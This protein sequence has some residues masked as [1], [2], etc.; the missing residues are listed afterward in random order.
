[1]W[2]QGFLAAL[3]PMSLLWLLVGTIWGLVVGVL[4]ALG[5]NF[6]V[7][8]MLP[9]T[10]GMDPG[11]AL[12]FLTA[13]HAST[14]Y[15]DSLSSILL[16][17]PGGPG[18][19]A[20]CW[21]G[22]PMARQGKAGRALGIA[23][24]SSFIGGS[25]AWLSLALLAR[26]VG[27]L[28]LSIGAPEYFALGV[29]ALSLVS[30][31]ARGETIKGLI[32]VCLGLLLASIGQD[33]V[34]GVSYRFA[35]GLPWLEAGI[36]IVVSTLGIFAMAQIMNLMEETSIGTA[37]MEVKDSIFGGFLETL[38]RPLTL[39]RAGLVGWFIG[40]LPALG[41]SLAGISSYLVEKHYSRE[42][43]HFGA[44]APAGLVAAE[45]GKGACVVGD[46]IPTFTLGVPGSVTGAILMAALVIHG[47]DPGPRFLL[48]GVLP[49]MVFASLFLSQAAYLLIGPGVCRA[50]AKIIFLPNAI[51][52]PVITVLAFVGAF[53]ERNF[54]FDILVMLAF[55][56]LAYGLNRIGYP[57]VCLVLGLI[58][59]DMVESNL[60]RSLGIGFGSYAIF[61][62]RPIAVVLLSVTLLF[63]AYP[64]LLRFF[65]IKGLE[66]VGE[67]SGEGE[68]AA[69]GAVANRAEAAALIVVGLV[70]AAFILIGRKYP[71]EV[72]LFPT[73]VAYVGLPITLFRLLGLG[74]SM[75]RHRGKAPGREK[76][77]ESQYRPVTPW[78][79]SFALFLVYALLVYLAGFVL[80]TVVF[81]IVTGFTAGYRKLPVLVAVGIGAGVFTLVFARLLN[82]ILPLGAIFEAILDR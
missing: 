66:G 30:V 36:P 65:G 67:R 16:N 31:A 48:S 58:L 73:L 38:R 59:G 50:L 33:P 22:H 63:L 27:E 51:L 19:V 43:D 6:S 54:T 74:W 18:T 21:D 76:P 47:I 23:T 2:F 49:Y 41:V 40:I 14:N 46:L 78:Y 12:V 24:L 39:L 61:L 15:G 80:A 26:P 34:S 62:Q 52:A 55:G 81:V 17:V 5:S 37:I 4:P 56:L 69:G 42:R 60:A 11:L 57:V 45:V 35:F 82:V 68:E 1:M 10:F 28:A 25:I 13:V 3:S 72:R 64:Y 7:A 77:V 79:V 75:R 44:G 71:E 70:M 29:M 53:T 20:T 9:F 32:M 8:L